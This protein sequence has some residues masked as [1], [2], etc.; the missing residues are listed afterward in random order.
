M[1]RRCGDKNQSKFL[2]MLLQY[3]CHPFTLFNF[4]V[5]TITIP[6]HDYSTCHMSFHHDWP[7]LDS[8]EHL[9]TMICDGTMR[10]GMVLRGMGTG[11]G[12]S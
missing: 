11:T 7:E 5:T 10:S 4:L 2:S 12:S 9:G 1:P 8:P 3:L 6:G